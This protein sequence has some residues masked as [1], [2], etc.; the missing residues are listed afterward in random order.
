MSGDMEKATN[1]QRL[2]IMNKTNKQQ[3]I[4][5]DDVLKKLEHIVAWFD[6]QDEPKLEDGLKKIEEAAILLE[7]SRNRLRE[8]ENRFEE[9]K[10]I[11]SKLNP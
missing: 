11:S 7:M 5:I 8:I 2:R 1:D 6:R 4:D 10:K 9:V 3:P